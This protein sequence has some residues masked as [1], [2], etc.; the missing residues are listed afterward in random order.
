MRPAVAFLSVLALS[1]IFAADTQTIELKTGE[2]IQGVFKRASAT[3]VVIE[4]AGQLVTLPLAKVNTIYLGTLPSP[5]SRVASTSA[6]PESTDAIEALKAVQSVVSSGVTFRDYATRVLDAKVQVDRYLRTSS[7]HSTKRAAIGSAMRFYEL[8]SL[9]WGSKLS[10]SFDTSEVVGNAIRSEQGISDCPQMQQIAAKYS[11]SQSAVL[12]IL[13]GEHQ[14]AFWTCAAE[15]IAEAESGGTSYSK[16]QRPSIPEK[17]PNSKPTV[18][19]L[20]LTSDP[21]GAEVLIDNVAHGVTPIADIDLPPGSHTVTI[22]K[23]GYR[24][25]ELKIL[26][27]QGDARAFK[28]HLTAEE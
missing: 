8:A 2:R 9:A 19:V 10:N 13:A 1:S 28:A 12:G 18:G 15:K 23:P 5:D 4:I 20:R 14:P 17:A 24:N 7:N 11:G 16:I 3:G 6:V 25:W 21:S 26:L 22:T 27:G